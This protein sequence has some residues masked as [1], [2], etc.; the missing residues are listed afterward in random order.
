MG[1]ARVRRGSGGQRRRGGPGRQLLRRARNRPVEA[2]RH[3][4]AQGPGGARR[5]ARREGGYRPARLDEPGEDASMTG[6]RIRVYLT[7]A[8]DARANYYG[9]EALAALR[10]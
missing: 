7:H 3:G 5:D 1:G 6:R 2:P 9:D 8:P 4:D 10:E